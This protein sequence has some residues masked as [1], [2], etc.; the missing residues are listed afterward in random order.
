MNNVSLDN[1]WK[2]RWAAR[3]FRSVAHLGYGRHGTCH[4]RHFDG[5][6]KNFLAK[7]KIFMYSFLSLYFAP[8]A[9]DVTRS[10]GTRDK[11][12]V[13]RP[14][15]RTSG[16]SEA[17]VLYWRKYLWHC[18]AFSAPHAVIRR[19]HADSARGELCPPCPSHYAPAPCIDKLQSCINT[20]SSPKALRRACCA[21][22]A[23]HYDKTLVLWHAKTRGSDIVTDKNARLPYLRDLLFLTL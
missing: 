14:H 13:C 11:K 1:W 15:V 9:R 4:G 18:W 16:H 19:P 7:I 17:Y 21:S 3:C 6:R 10:D 5:G 22:N 23:K 20:A 12:Q 8:Y 2:Q